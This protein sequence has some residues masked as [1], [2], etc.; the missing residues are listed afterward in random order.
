[1]L[2][3]ISFPKYI[4]VLNLPKN[5]DPDAIYVTTGTERNPDGSEHNFIE[6]W[7]WDSVNESWC[8]CDKQYHE[9]GESS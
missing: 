8:L 9:G 3:L 6:I 7:V 2:T 1:M 5:P 4:Y